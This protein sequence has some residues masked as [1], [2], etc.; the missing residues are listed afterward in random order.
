MN[1]SILI[2]GVPDTF[3]RLR[4]ILHGYPLR[5]VATLADA[6]NTLLASRPDLI[7][8][9][10]H[11][12][13]GSMFELFRFIKARGELSRTPIIC[14]RATHGAETRAKI[15]IQAVEMSV[16]A[17]GANAFIDIWECEDHYAA[18]VALRELV[19]KTLQQAPVRLDC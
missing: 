8:L 18:D 4:V 7:M 10:I 3:G 14:Y 9:G 5:F 12:D 19:I 1:K 6:Q 17:L 15:T 13:E 11:F 16:L 2:A